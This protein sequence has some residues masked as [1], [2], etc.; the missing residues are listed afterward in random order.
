MKCSRCGQEQSAGAN[1]C[2]VCGGNL[3]PDDESGSLLAA[4]EQDFQHLEALQSDFKRSLQQVKSNIFRLRTLLPPRPP[5]GG[6]PATIPAP[7]PGPEASVRG[8]ASPAPSAPAAPAA[9]FPATPAGKPAPLPAD[10]FRPAAHARRPPAPAAP[11]PPAFASASPANREMEI[12]L[13]QKWALGA[14]LVIIIF[15]VAYFL[16]YSIDK[17]WIG[18]VARLV[19]VYLLGAGMLA[20]GNLFRRRG[21]AVFG[22]TLAGGGL[23]VL[24]FGAYAGFQIFELVSQPVSFLFMI[25]ITCLGAALALAY[26]NRWLA[27]TALC[28]GFLTPFLLSTGQDNQFALMGYLTILN[29][30]LLLIAYFK[31]WPV[32]TLLG[33]CFT[34]M[35]FS[36]WYG[37]YYSDNRFWITLLFL[38][39]FFLIYTVI[40]FLYGLRSGSAGLSGFGLLPLNTFIGF[41]FSFAMIE[42]YASLPYV[43]LM[44]VSYAALLLSL[45]S[46]LNRRNQSGSNAF[47]LLLGQAMLFLV[48]TV[49]VLFSGHWITL[50]WAVQAWIIM[51]LAGRLKKSG[52]VRAAFVLLI[53]AAG[54]YLFYDYLVTFDMTGS[55]TG[56]STQLGERIITGCGLF[57]CLAACWFLAGRFRSVHGMAPLAGTV[58]TWLAAGAGLLGFAVLNIE[59]WHFCHQFLPEAKAAGLS[60]LWTLYSIALIITGFRFRNTACRV[61]SLV[62]LSG[63]I[64][65]VFLV[66]MAGVETPYRIL[67]F[68]ILGLFLVGVSFLYHR[69]KDRIMQ[70]M[71]KNNPPEASS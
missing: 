15:A 63:T 22:L 33:F 8:P 54:K 35:I 31:R 6:T 9:P 49:P 14:G 64:L 67:S 5:A 39:V 28:G 11:V 29:L 30:G 27:T 24:Y 1:Y 57:G 55:S 40:P 71:D 61:I 4:I 19:M 21:F 50:F 36:A 23:A 10:D 37:R 38:H 52:L 68:F 16:K 7:V 48:I 45:C 70:S 51:W 46:I 20:A 69:Y 47:F 32:I 34:Y 2:R 25:M 26:D 60:I 43:G 13:G 42:E 41:G 66:D 58:R 53:A 59:I 12:S 62:L 44:T 65:K 56:F 3:V 18:P 17:G